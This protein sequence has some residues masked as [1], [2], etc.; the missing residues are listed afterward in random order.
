MEAAAAE[1][2]R[3]REVAAAKPRSLRI[4]GT[5]HPNLKN[6]LQLLLEALVPGKTALLG[7]FLLGLK[8]GL[9]LPEQAWGA[10]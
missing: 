3:L 5:S 10:S 8:G 4:P 6:L 7:I 2:E 1:A 9:A